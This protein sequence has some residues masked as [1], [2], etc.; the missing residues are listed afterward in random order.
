MEIPHNLMSDVQA[1][2]VVLVLGAGAS[3]GSQND[4]G[5]SP[6]TGKD[7]AQIL[8]ARFLGGEHADNPLSVVAELAISESDLPT[9]QEYI[10]TI[11]TGFRPAGFH[12][13]LPTFKWTALATTNFDLVVERA[14]DACSAPSQELVPFV[15]NGDRVDENLRSPT[16]LM[17]IKLHGC[18]TRSTDSDVPLILSVDQYVSHR[19]G[20]E[21]IF[22]HLKYLAFEHPIVF[23]GH[24]LQD[25]DIRHMLLELGSSE[26]RPRFYT[27]TP[28]VTGPEQRYWGGRRITTLSGTF[29]EF[30][31]TLDSQ[32]A[33]PLRGVVPTAPR[34]G[35]PVS[36]RFVVR[37]PSI[38]PSCLEFL[39]ND[40][41]YVKSGMPTEGLEDSRLF[42]RGHNPRWAAVTQDL[43]VK[44][45]IQDTVLSDAIL[46]DDGDQG[47]KLFVI[48]G[49]AGSGKT[50]LLQRI[51]WEAALEFNRLCLYVRNGGQFSYD[52]LRELSRLVDERIYLFIDD[53]DEHFT[54]TLQLLQTA[55]RSQFRLT[56]VAAA[57]INEWNMTC[58]DLDPYVTDEFQVRYLSPQEI[59]RL[60]ELL[61]EHRALFLLE[62]SSLEQRRAAFLE[63]A[64]RQLLVALHE[65][66]LGKPFEDIIADEFAE[67]RPDAARLMYLG[68]CFLN[69]YGVAVRAGVIARVYNI[70]FTDFRDFFF[71]PLEGLV[72]ARFDSRTRDYVYETRHPHI[73][74]IVVQRILSKPHERLDM[75]LKMINSI[76]IDYGTDRV[77][78]RKLVRGR[79]LLD[80]LPD[81]QMVEAV[82]GAAQSAVG[83]DPYLLH[84]MA[85]YEFHRPNGNLNRAAQTLARA[86]ELAPYDKTIHHS[87]AELQLRRADQ[88]QSYLEFEKYISEARKIAAT[89]VES[90]STDSHG[91]H[92]LAKTYLAKLQRLQSANTA[93]FDIEFSEVVKEAEELIETGLQRF[94]GDPFLLQADSELGELLADG[95]RSERA[96][97]TAFQKNPHN[98]FIAVRLAKLYVR[99]GRTYEALEIYREALDF[100]IAE[101]RVHYNY[102]ILLMEQK[103]KD[104]NLVE[105][106]LR[107]GFSDGDANVEAQFWY[108]RQ[109]YLN[110]RISD[111]HERFR[112]LKSRLGDP[113]SKR[114]LRGPVSSNGGYAFFTGRV[115]RLEADYGFVIRDGT[116]DRVFLHRNNVQASVWNLLSRNSR[117]QFAVAFNFWGPAAF[118]VALE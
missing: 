19:K 12:Q 87:R 7:L 90:G 72:F 83:E 15:K 23:V 77:A 40:V 79:S 52:V 50:V 48:K 57:R 118:E 116:A 53:I 6:P 34:S 42:Y 51:A 74:E 101:K 1:G 8:A 29:E 31:T 94:P 112:E 68:I 99:T 28:D 102:A 30:L 33:S 11:F 96:L 38:G 80:E 56:I 117:V 14:Y 69:Q 113:R 110:G 81:H 105:Y 26:S 71:P 18:I 5:D 106:H 49:H 76:N 36:D 65:A 75:L 111:S 63:R 46:E 41:D 108:A 88:A 67:I 45:D 70:R 115:E 61:E 114:L 3:M 64:G 55:K 35:V 92:T 91:M 20:R 54:R 84:Q 98:P 62:R 95:E 44:R 22:D 13:L 85:I 97:H 60:L 89:L 103:E 32:I 43:D 10:R 25:P 93:N 109:L 104:E 86:Q 107:R 9:V 24:S 47:C 17:F 39:N 82:Y 21:R 73:A 16:S 58:E 4:N 27:V 2:N 37:E 66:T 100:G 59:D 78:F